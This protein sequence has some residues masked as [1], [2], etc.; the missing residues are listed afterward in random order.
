VSFKQNYLQLF[1][2]TYV[3]YKTNEDNTFGVSYGRRIERPEYE[4]LNPFRFQ[5]DRYT[6]DQGNPNLRPQYSNNVE[7]SY[8]YKGALNVSANYTMTTDIIS[9]AVIS[10]KAPGD[11]NY[12][13][14]TTSQNLASERN[15]GLAVNYS[16]QLLKGWNLNVFFNVFNNHNKGVVDSTKIDVSYTSFNGN[17]NSQYAFKKGWTAELSGFYAAKNYFNGVLFVQ[18]RGMFSVGG[19][20]Q[21]LDG[22]G[23]L[24]LNLRD[25]F[26]LMSFSSQSSLYKGITNNRNV[27]DNRR[28]VMTFVYRFGKTAGNQPQRRNGGANDEQGRVGGGGQQQ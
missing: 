20:K 4:S 25:P 9:Q 18:G 17:F 3:T 7:I 1:P 5:L 2:T 8:N 13:T 19:S 21:I 6:Y 11:S 23:S 24:K 22:K 14:Y 26:Y 16:K 27:W 28:I 12:T 15:F 10:F